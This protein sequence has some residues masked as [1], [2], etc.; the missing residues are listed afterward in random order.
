LVEVSK[1]ADF[2]LAANQIYQH[3]ALILSL[4]VYS[5]VICKPGTLPRMIWSGPQK[6]DFGSPICPYGLGITATA[7]TPE[8]ED[9]PH[10]VFISRR[11]GASFTISESMDVENCRKAYLAGNLEINVM[12]MNAT[13]DVIGPIT[14]SNS[15]WD[16]KKMK[17]DIP[18]KQ[19]F[20][21]KTKVPI[22]DDKAGRNLR[23]FPTISHILQWRATV[24][25]EEPAFIQI[26]ARGREQ[27]LIT[28]R[29]LASK[30]YSL[31][32]FLVQKKGIAPG[33]HVLVMTTLSLDYM[34]LIHACLYA[35]IVPIPT[36]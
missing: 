13:P 6:M 8:I 32:S 22:L 27:K 25:P 26:D 15:G 14:M 33:E 2:T 23:E 36:R 12:I 28:Y 9:N 16:E 31:A 19:I 4:R 30:V 29:K 1:K 10:G 34:Y 21:D 7:L 3:L 11:T 18:V 24:L 20:E 17:K 35:G 5:V